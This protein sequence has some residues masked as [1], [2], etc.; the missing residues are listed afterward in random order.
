M[1][2]IGQNRFSCMNQAPAN[3]TEND[4]QKYL[5]LQFWPADNTGERSQ[6]TIEKGTV[7]IGQHP[8]ELENVTSGFHAGP[9]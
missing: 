9:F 2:H 3:N 7:Y 5:N 4:R 1:L 6:F 8:K